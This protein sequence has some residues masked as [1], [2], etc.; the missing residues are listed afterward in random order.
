MGDVRGKAVFVREDLNVPM[1]DGAVTDNTRLRAAMPTIN[2]LSDRGAKVLVLAHFGRPK[3]Q[4]NMAYSLEPV[5]APF[6]QVLGRPVSFMARPTPD[7]IDSLPEGG[8]AVVENSRFAAGEEKNDPDMAKMLAS[9]AS[10]YV[11]D[12]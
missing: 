11:N 5:V 6:T 4:V 12:A 10:F 2:E 1:K 9:L 3:G 8:I 7:A